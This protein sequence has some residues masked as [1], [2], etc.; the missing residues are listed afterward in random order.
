MILKNVSVITNSC[1]ARQSVTT[2]QGLSQAGLGQ[3]NWPWHFSSKWP[4]M[5]TRWWWIAGQEMNK[6]A[7]ANLW[8][9]PRGPNVH[10]KMADYEFMCDLPKLLHWCNIYRLERRNLIFFF[11]DNTDL[12]LDF[13]L[14]HMSRETYFNEWVGNITGMAF[15]RIL[16]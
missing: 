14:V 13:H 3:N 4:R 9:L 15:S 8:P 11:D 12:L 2:N 5:I 16:T 7:A 10:W 6:W 1:K